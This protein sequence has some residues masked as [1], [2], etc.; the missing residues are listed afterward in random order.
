[1]ALHRPIRAP[2][3]AALSALESALANLSVSGSGA[4]S[5]LR[6]A[7]IGRRYASH[8]SQGRA[9][10]AKDGPGKRLGAKKTAGEYVVPGNI[11]FKQR[12]T[13]WFPG[14]GCHMVCFHINPSLDRGINS[15]G[16]IGQR[17]HHPR[18]SPRLRDLLSRPSPQRQEEIHR[19]RLQARE[20]TASSR[21]CTSETTARHARLSDATHRHRRINGHRSAIHTIRRS[22]HRC[23]STRN[24]RPR[25][26]AGRE[27]DSHRRDE[28]SQS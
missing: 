3:I 22:G 12:G 7:R 25:S 20:H 24:H 21:Q 15:S 26:T 11:L 10:G 1:M 14:D 2:S 5:A 16:D 23:R 28:A 13:L 8:Q 6:F 17:P 4:A 9:N 18:L 19:H 27:E